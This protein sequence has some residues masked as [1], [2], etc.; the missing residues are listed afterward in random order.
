M[1]ALSPRA[2][3]AIAALVLVA[4]AA[5]ALSAHA[6]RV[7]RW[8]G[9]SGTVRYGDQPP[10][11]DPAPASVQVI[12]MDAEPGAIAR[13]S[14][15]NAEDGYQALAENALAGPV[16]VRLR[17]SRA[18]NARGEPELPARATVP[19]YDRTLVARIFG[20]DGARPA[21]FELHLDA[22]PGQP[23]ARHRDVEYVFPLRT[24]DLRVEQGFGGGFSHHDEQNR[25]AVDFAAPLGTDVLAARD[26]VVM[27]VENDFDRAGLNQEKYAGRANFVRIVHDDGTMALYAHLQER[28]V[29]VRMGQHVRAGQLIGRSGNTG[30]TSGPHLHFAVQANQGMRLVAVPFRMFG[31]HGILRFSAPSNGGAQAALNADAGESSAR[32][33]IR[34]RGRISP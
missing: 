10:A 30:F 13:L 32:A 2:R 29:M 9:A 23:G 16:E 18:R 4:C 26:G 24:H 21:D 34:L 19:A 28:G 15:V 22:V 20:V 7:Y 25:Y 33:G 27:Q 5:A 8:K 12:P 14:V 6:T 3:G 1:R 11:G 17:F 31:P